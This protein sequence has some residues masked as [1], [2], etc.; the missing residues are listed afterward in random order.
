MSIDCPFRRP[1]RAGRVV[2]AWHGEEDG[3]SQKRVESVEEGQDGNTGLT[4]ATDVTS[5]GDLNPASLF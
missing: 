3:Q 2:Y 4:G 5:T 1:S